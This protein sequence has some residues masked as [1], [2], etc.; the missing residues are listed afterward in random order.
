M[1]MMKKCFLTMV[2]MTLFVRV[3]A[4]VYYY[5]EEGK[6]PYST[7]AGMVLVLVRDNS[8][9]L[10]LYG[11]DISLVQQNLMKNRDYY[12]NAFNNGGRTEDSVGFY[13]ALGINKKTAKCYVCKIEKKLFTFNSW[14]YRDIALGL[15]FQTLILNADTSDPMYF[16]SYPVDTFIPRHSV[17]DLF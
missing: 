7:S 12:V 6:D 13:L 3:S 11:E 4:Q 16:Q 14:M 17:D 1:E 5:V 2:L 10:W 15:D 8:G 9:Y